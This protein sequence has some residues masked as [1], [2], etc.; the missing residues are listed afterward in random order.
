MRAASLIEEQGCLK[1]SGILNFVTI[2][3]LW[4][5]SLSFFTKEQTLCISLADVT[6]A[7]SGGLA[8]M[9]EW[10]K[11]ANDLNKTI[12]FKKIPLNLQSIIDIAGI[13]HLFMENLTKC[14]KEQSVIPG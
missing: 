8:L 11:Y 13:D 12:V 2:L 1:I 4:E 3:K 14:K 9:I 6:H 10:I 7:N 5:E